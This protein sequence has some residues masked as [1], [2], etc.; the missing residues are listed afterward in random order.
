ME[1]VLLAAILVVMIGILVAM[2]FGLNEVIK[3]L[4]SIDGQLS[5]TRPTHS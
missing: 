4:E 2:K 3:G 1:T 5:K